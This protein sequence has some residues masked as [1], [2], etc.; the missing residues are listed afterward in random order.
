[1]NG[2][3]WN[4]AFQWVGFN[5]WLL[6]CDCGCTG[7]W[8]TMSS[9]EQDTDFLVLSLVIWFLAEKP[10]Q[11]KNGAQGIRKSTAFLLGP[12]NGKVRGKRSCC[13]KVLVFHFFIP[14]PQTYLS[15]E[16][17]KRTSFVYL[18]LF[19]SCFLAVQE[20]YLLKRLE[21]IF[22]FGQKALIT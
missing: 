15:A 19:A 20:F 21:Q 13:S 5:L 12:A 3:D 6:S 22:C 11:L 8:G 1:M 14:Y 17:L 9:V 4:I 10:L 7:Q 18:F 2:K 16:S